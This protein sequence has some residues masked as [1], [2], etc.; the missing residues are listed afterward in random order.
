MSH[1]SDRLIRSTEF[2]PPFSHKVSPFHFAPTCRP[3]YTGRASDRGE[4]NQQASRVSPDAAGPPRQLIRKPIMSL[5]SALL[6]SFM[7][8]GTCPSVKVS[9]APRKIWYWGKRLTSLAFSVPRGSLPLL[10]TSINIP[11][12]T[13]I[14]HDVQN[15]DLANE[16]CATSL[17]KKEPLSRDAS[18]RT[19]K[20]RWRSSVIRTTRTT[21]KQTRNAKEVSFSLYLLD[22]TATETDL[23]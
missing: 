16:R 17:I 7:E 4:S 15:I 14:R 23:R 18:I 2:K 9:N 1:R 21:S 10:R 12:R 22:Q 13:F 3:A 20:T 5:A 6:E 19:T 11:C 8:P